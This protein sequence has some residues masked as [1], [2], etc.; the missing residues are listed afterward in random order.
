MFILKFKKSTILTITFILSLL[1]FISIANSNIRLSASA[2]SSLSVTEV[3]E[4]I[5]AVGVC[6]IYDHKRAESDEYYVGGLHYLF[7]IDTYYYN[8]N[9][10]Y[11]WLRVSYSDYLKAFEEESVQTDYIKRFDELGIAYG[12]ID[13]TPM[14]YNTIHN[15]FYMNLSYYQDGYYETPPTTSLEDRLKSEQFLVIFVKDTNTNEMA[16]SKPIIASYNS[17]LNGTDSD[18]NYYKGLSAELSDENLQLK[19]ELAELK[20]GTDNS[21]N[22]IKILSVIAVVVLVFAVIGVIASIA[23]RKK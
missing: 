3:A 11:G 22:F 12:V 21:F 1:M 19:A 2:D 15:Y 6:H 5:H 20:T 9:Y 4:K 10:A 13:D 16:Y 17:V 23:P 14:N 7:N 18:L 8:S